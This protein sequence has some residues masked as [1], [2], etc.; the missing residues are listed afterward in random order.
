MRPLSDYE[1]DAADEVAE[2]A[3]EVRFQRQH[4]QRVLAHP[5]CRDPDHPGCGLCEGS[6]PESVPAGKER[7]DG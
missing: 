7:L 1:G 6:I 3:A 4:M 2:L 5:D